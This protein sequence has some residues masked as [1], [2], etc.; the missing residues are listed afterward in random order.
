MKR[1]L[2]WLGAI[3]LIGLP[4]VTVAQ[5]LF[6][7]EQPGSAIIIR[8]SNDDNFGYHCVYDFEVA[9]TTYGTPNRQKRSGTA[10][11]AVKANG[12]VFYIEQGSATDLHMLGSPSIQ[13]TET[14]PPPPPQPVPAPPH[15]SPPLAD[16]V[17]MQNGLLLVGKANFTQIN[18]GFREITLRIEN[19]CNVSVNINLSGRSGNVWTRLHKVELLPSKTT[20]YNY[21]IPSAWAGTTEEWYQSS[22]HYVSREGQFIPSA[23]GRY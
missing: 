14:P 20:E 18:I 23:D 13:C 3:G 12:I 1:H 11:V 10:N 2:V 17:E 8:V 6:S 19:K 15:L 22:I 16:C 5:P 4:A 21:D 9:W 7:T